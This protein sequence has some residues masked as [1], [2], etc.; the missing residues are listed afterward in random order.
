MLLAEGGSG[1]IWENQYKHHQ[2][3]IVEVA[4]EHKG[5]MFDI[6]AIETRFVV[7]LRERVR[8]QI[9]GGWVLSHERLLKLSVNPR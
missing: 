3:S 7:K 1:K 6:C 8:F 4:E 9:V 5:G 2:K